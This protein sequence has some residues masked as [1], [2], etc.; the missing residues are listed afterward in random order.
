[1]FEEERR[2]E[3]GGEQ[4]VAA[5]VPSGRPGVVRCDLIRDVVNE[6][7][8]RQAA[9]A[10]KLSEQLT[11]YMMGE[12][13]RAAR[14]EVTQWQG[15]HIEDDV[16]NA[17]SVL[18]DFS[19]QELLERYGRS[20][21]THV[22]IAQRVELQNALVHSTANKMIFKPA[23][24]Y[25]DWFPLAVEMFLPI[26][27]QLRKSMGIA[28][29]SPS[30]TAG[31]ILRLLP[32]VRDWTPEQGALRLGL[33]EVKNKPPLKE[34]LLKLQD[35][36]SPLVRFRRIKSVNVWELNVDALAEVLGK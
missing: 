26:L 25:E 22:Q 16:R 6:H 30:N 36:K 28:A 18:G 14:A 7:R 12:P 27:V 15:S 9:A 10:A 31:D 11:P 19:V 35:E 24:Q 20:C 33:I 34:L 23:S 8:I 5:R 2:G 1:M 4:G 3:A 13:W 21:R 29:A 17:G 32:R